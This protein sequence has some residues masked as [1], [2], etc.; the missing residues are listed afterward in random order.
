MI[1]ATRQLSAVPFASVA[2]VSTSIW[3]WKLRP[4]VGAPCCQ[5]SRSMSLGHARRTSRLCSSGS[6]LPLG[7]GAHPFLGLAPPLGGQLLNSS[8]GRH[9]VSPVMERKLPKRQ[10]SCQVENCQ[11]GNMT[12]NQASFAMTNGGESERPKTAKAPDRAGPA[13]SNLTTDHRSGR[14]EY[15]VATG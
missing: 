1:R 15:L 8:G 13:P 10:H 7:M 9:R 4:T 3:H 6:S 5:G 2:F 14:G 11:I 12:G